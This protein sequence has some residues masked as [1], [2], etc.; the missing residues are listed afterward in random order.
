MKNKE[1]T[2]PEV[3]TYLAKPRELQP[4]YAIVARKHR[5][6]LVD[7]ITRAPREVNLHMVVTIELKTA[8]IVAATVAE[9]GED[10]GLMA[11][12]SV[13]EGLE[14]ACREHKIAYRAE[15]LVDMPLPSSL[16]AMK[17]V[18]LPKDIC[19]TLGICC[20]SYSLPAKQHSLLHDVLTAFHEEGMF[21]CYPAGR[22]V[23]S[24]NGGYFTKSDWLRC[25]IVS[26]IWY[27]N[28]HNPSLPDF[29]GGDCKSPLHLASWILRSQTGTGRSISAD[30]IRQALLPRVDQAN[31]RGSDL[32]VTVGPM[33]N[34]KY[35]PRDVRVDRS[36][37]GAEAQRL[38]VR[39]DPRDISVVW[40]LDSESGELV[41]Y[42]LDSWHP[43]GMSWIEALHLQRNEHKARKAA[44]AA[45]I[46]ADRE[47]LKSQ[48]LT[49]LINTS[50][51]AP[52]PSNE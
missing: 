51:A 16:L 45:I 29:P 7:E 5:A 28:T 11:L 22:S 34:L 4:P 15:D 21:V 2:K 41:P 31:F 17:G 47:E 24:H 50:S 19:A 26:A 46:A 42:D 32:F 35:W 30:Q 23:V 10:V 48:S 6:V 8:Y 20:K 1:T 49:T 25:A 14:G 13:A 43:A 36:W 38:D 52:A 39:Y 9:E 27:N 3:I 33:R 37:L 44:H 18:H 12:L 40:V